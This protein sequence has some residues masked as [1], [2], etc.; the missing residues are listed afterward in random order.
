M[1]TLEAGSWLVG[2]LGTGSHWKMAS[3]E[4][5]GAKVVM[6]KRLGLGAELEVFAMEGQ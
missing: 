3:L 6:A 4:L 5:A 2:N 1:G